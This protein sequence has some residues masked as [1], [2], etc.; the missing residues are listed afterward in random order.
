M[1]LF[2]VQ[3]RRRINSF[4]VSCCVQVA[5]LSAIGLFCTG[6]LLCTFPCV[7]T[8]PIE[9]EWKTLVLYAFLAVGF[10]IL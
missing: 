6:S 9:V 5:L 3:N 2:S 1:L 8:C 7:F 10:Y 4:I